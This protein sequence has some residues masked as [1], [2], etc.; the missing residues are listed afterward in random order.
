MSRCGAFFTVG[1]LSPNRRS[2]LDLLAVATFAGLWYIQRSR[3]SEIVGS[4]MTSRRAIL[5]FLVWVAACSG[6]DGDTAG[7]TPYDGE[8]VG[9]NLSFEIREGELTAWHVTGIRCDATTQSGSPCSEAYNGVIP[10][11][12]LVPE[13]GAFKGTLG[14][15]AIT[16]QFHS[17]THVIGTWTFLPEKCCTSSGTWEAIYVPP[18]VVDPPPILEERQPSTPPIE[19]GGGDGIAAQPGDYRVVDGASEAQ[20]IALERTN[21]YRQNVGV[22]LVDMDVAINQAAQAHA[23]YYALHSGAYAAGSVPGGAHSESAALPEGFTGENFG[24]RLNAAGYQGAPGFEVMAFLGD[25]VAAVDGWVETVYHRIPFVSPDMVDA[26]YGG[27]AGVDVMDF[28][29]SGYSDKDL[30]VVYPWPG[31]VDLP[32]SWGG[33]EAPQP[34]PPSSGYPSGTVITLTTAGGSSLT[35]DLHQLLD[36]SGNE[37]A[38][39]W[40]ERGSNGFLSETWAMYAEQ[41]LQKGSTYTVHVEGSLSNAPWTK[42]WSFTTRP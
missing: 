11:E 39:V 26:G 24:D 19:V 5:L 32:A 33:N 17:R 8:W 27:A 2:A 25:P 37:V 9:E 41:P 36:A 6:S 21:W 35:L 12:S 22:P 38:H 18:L 34:P 3:F 13:G 31:Q 29:R 10:F 23:D 4:M 40:L 1:P 7:T 30:V 28:G 15:V 16:G 14:P 42:T 20:R